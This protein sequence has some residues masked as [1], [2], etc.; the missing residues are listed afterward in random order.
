MDALGEQEWDGMGITYRYDF[1]P[2]AALK[3]D[4]FRGE[5]TLPTVGDYTVWSVGVDMVF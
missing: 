1:H 2:S 3:I 5:N 4:Y